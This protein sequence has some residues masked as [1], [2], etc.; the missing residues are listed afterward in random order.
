M[1]NSRFRSH[2]ISCTLVRYLSANF[3]LKRSSGEWGVAIWRSFFQNPGQN[4]IFVQ[5]LGHFSLR[6]P[7]FKCL[8]NLNRRELGDKW[9][10]F[11]TRNDS[12]TTYVKMEEKGEMR[13]YPPNPLIRDNDS[14]AHDLKRIAVKASLDYFYRS[15]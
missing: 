14:A 8:Y 15:R 4:T 10:L 12:F 5:F 13:F 9:A 1:K 6:R 3:Q 11:E 2:Q 7:T